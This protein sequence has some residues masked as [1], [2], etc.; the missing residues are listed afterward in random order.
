MCFCFFWIVFLIL[1]I[2][3][4]LFWILLWIFVLNKLFPFSTSISNFV[5]FWLLQNPYYVILIWICLKNLV[6]DFRTPSVWLNV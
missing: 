6:C 5:L 4:F 1:A 2:R 3:F